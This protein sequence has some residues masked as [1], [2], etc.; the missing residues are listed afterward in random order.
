MQEK[1]K[2]GW[3][4]KEFA[5]VTAWVGGEFGGGGMDTYTCMAESLCSS[6]QNYHNIVNQLHPNTKQKVK[7][8]K[9]KVCLCNYPC[10]KRVCRN[11]VS[12]MVR[13]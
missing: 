13:K 3:P 1:W 4:F 7:K 8:I 5:A 12:T 6:S 11:L 9:L 2:L 10:D